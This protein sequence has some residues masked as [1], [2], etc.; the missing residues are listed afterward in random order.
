M[1]PLRPRKN[2]FRFI[3]ILG[4]LCL[5][6]SPGLRVNM[7]CPVDRRIGLRGNK[8]PRPAIEHI[9]KAVFGGLHDYLSL[10]TR[11]LQIRKDHLLGRGKVPVIPRCGLVVPH[12]STRFRIDGKNRRKVQIISPAG[13]A[14]LARIRRGVSGTDVEKTKLCVVDHGIPHC[15]AEPDIP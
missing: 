7:T 5:Y 10:D 14:Q 8:F 2:E 3:K 12:Q 9:E 13:T 6:G 4:L 11:Y 15:P 1:G